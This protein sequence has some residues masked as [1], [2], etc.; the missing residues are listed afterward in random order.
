MTTL[1]MPSQMFAPRAIDPSF[2]AEYRA[3]QAAGFDVVLLDQARMDEGAW[4]KVAARAADRGPA[5]YRGW[6]LTPADYAAMYAALLARGTTVHTAPDA[7]TAVHTLPG[8]YAHVRGHTPFS[9]WVPVD[10]E[11]RV[12]VDA[13]L[14]VA[15]VHR[16]ALGTAGV[17]VKDYVKSR[18]HEWHEACF[19]PADAHGYDEA[20]LERVV[21][22]FIDRQA[23][24][25]VGGVVLRAFVPFE[26]V[27]THP[28]SGMPITAEHRVFVHRGVPLC[29]APYWRDGTYAGPAADVQPA[30]DQLTPVFA[31]CADAVQSP[32]FTADVALGTDGQWRV[33]ELGD[34]QVAGLLGTLDEHAFYRALHAALTGAAET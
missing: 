1:L 3:A 17:L 24:R 20:A 2:D 12:S 8:I 19:V 5:L 16:D 29:S 31:A 15:R 34:G 11:G 26:S 21:R 28:K 4:S 6:M 7:Y 10:A 32:L 13:V 25:L 30:L 9:V 22:T 23:E 14:D 18:K 33:V 27:G